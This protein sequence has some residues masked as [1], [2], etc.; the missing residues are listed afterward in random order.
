[1]THTFSR[2]MTDQFRVNVLSL[3]YPGYG[4]LNG[5]QATEENLYLVCVT[6]LRFL[7][8]DMNV[9]YPQIIAMGRSIGSGPACYLASKYPLG[10]LLLISP[11]SSIRTAIHSVAGKMLSN[12]F[13]EIFSNVDQI[14]NVQCPT[15]LIHG[16]RDQLIP[17]EHSVNLLRAC[18][19]TRKKLV[20]PSE[21]EHNSNL[22]SH[23][24]FLAIPVISFFGLPG[25]CTS[26]APRMPVECG[27]QDMLR[28]HLE[29]MERGEKAKKS[30][31][32]EQELAFGWLCKSCVVSLGDNAEVNY[33]NSRGNDLSSSGLGTHDSD[34]Q[35]DA[36]DM[37]LM[38]EPL[39]GCNTP[40]AA[41]YG[42]VYEKELYG[43]NNGT[44][45]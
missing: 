26:R 4:L 13:P 2:H 19:A 16:K 6:A 35:F 1:M 39:S 10:G 30:N 33:A 29:R 27:A 45:S 7:V 31:L 23:A 37:P 3:E 20:C 9:K 11:F 43:R 41:P 25:Y 28:R 40:A 42:G 14:A 15:L 21:M 5:C 38:G 22:F 8:D 44:P 34:G 24:D 12:F 18:R 32:R 17:S 36:V